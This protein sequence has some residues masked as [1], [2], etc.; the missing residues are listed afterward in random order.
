MPVS[1]HPR[2]YKF[3]RR[4]AAACGWFLYFYE[5]VHVS[6]QTPRAEPVSFAVLLILATLL[7]HAGIA[8]WIAHNRRLAARGTRGRMT[9]YT[10]PVFTQDYLGRQLVVHE[11]TR[12]SREVIV[13]IDGDTKFYLPALT[14]Q[15][16]K[17]PRKKA[18]VRGN[19]RAK[20]RVPV[21]EL[22]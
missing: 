3:L 13:R 17:P 22:V 7:M 6:W 15:E 19:S 9:R 20:L 21:A 14:E 1:R 4:A 16:A 12:T 18:G 5:W 2:L 10:V 8:A 11:A